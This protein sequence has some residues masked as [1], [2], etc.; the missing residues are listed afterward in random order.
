MKTI[1]ELTEDYKNSG[2]AFELYKSLW[3]KLDNMF[4]LGTEE[5]D[6]AEDLRGEME[7]IWYALTKEEKDTMNKF[8]IEYETEKNK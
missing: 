6:E 7:P 2:K 4:D 5:S 8:Y 3:I 1:K